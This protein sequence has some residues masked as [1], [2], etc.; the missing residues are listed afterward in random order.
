MDMHASKK[1]CT[2]LYKSKVH[3]WFYA[4]EAHKGGFRAHTGGVEEQV[5]KGTLIT[6]LGPLRCI[7]EV[8]HPALAAPPLPPL[9]NL[10]EMKRK[11]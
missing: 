10:L 5:N 6:L 2:G 4:Q 8:N 9:Q 3:R 7:K 1:L 11:L